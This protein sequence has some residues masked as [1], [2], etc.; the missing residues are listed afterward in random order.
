MATRNAPWVGPQST[1]WD[2][3]TFV[4][5]FGYLEAGRKFK[6]LAGKPGTIKFVREDDSASGTMH[7]KIDLAASDVVEGWEETRFNFVGSNVLTVGERFPPWKNDAD[8]GATWA[9]IAEDNIKLMKDPSLK[10]AHIE[11]L[12]DRQF[13]VLG[14]Y[15]PDAVELASGQLAGIFLLTI[16]FGH[17]PDGGATGPPS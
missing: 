12:F 17:S 13:P 2:N 1:P 7:L 5:Q 3:L 9:L 10:L 11:G 15:L 14:I 16:V 8:T 6:N 4:L